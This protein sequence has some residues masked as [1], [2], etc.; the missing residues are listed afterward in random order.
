MAER[1]LAQARDQLA[2]EILGLTRDS[3][4]VALR[5]LGVALCQLEFAPAWGLEMAPDGGAAIATDGRWLYYSPIP[6]LSRYKASREW[7]NH[8][9]LHLV[10]HC[11]FYH[12]F[13]EPGRDAVRWSLACDIAVENVIQELDLR[14]TANAAASRQ[15]PVLQR[16]QHELKRLTADRVY[17]Y[18][19]G[20]AY[21]E[22]QLA[23]LGQLFY[24]D[25]HTV[26]FRQPED[27]SISDESGE[28]ETDQE[29]AGRGPRG[30]A[31]TEPQA[32]PAGAD[33]EPPPPE[34]APE[35]GPPAGDAEPAPPQ[36]AP[37][38]AGPQ[39]PP[40]T[41]P[42]SSAEPQQLSAPPA[43]SAIWRDISERVQVDLETLSRQWAE[44]SVAFTAN[45]QTANRE[46]YDYRS[47]L[48]RFMVLGETMQVSDDEFDYVYYTYGLRLYRRMPL[49]EPLE[50]QDVRKI[51]DFVIAI[52]TSGSCSGELVQA[53]MR[54]TCSILRQS[55]NFFQKFNVHI[56]QCDAQIR[57]VA[58]I[59]DLAEFE[60]YIENIRLQGFGLTDF[61]PVFRYVD[62]MIEQKAF[63]NLKGLLYFTDGY[64]IFPEH[65]PVYETA[66]VF[67]DP[68]DGTPD[69]PPWAIRL[70]LMPEDL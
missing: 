17:R 68:A 36:A 42:H 9:Y 37:A 45:I 14:Q 65:K 44:R 10:L 58:R 61:R 57:S 50:Y 54:K 53:F 64:G 29:Q 32:A 7:L 59:T 30:T 25:D 4:L 20:Q 28:D 16:L 60:Q 5:F 63:T 21:T 19:L 12:P 66:F 67:L 48:E 38:G 62:Q 34:P 55:E 3:L 33:A 40:E 23:E 27:E 31:E 26:W 47:F 39:S 51:R 6:L 56:L 41:A 18:L 24:H 1:D 11:L 70:V 2:Q 43:T 49:I 22:E 46:R 35:S 69:V 13:V 52:D 15:L 8:D